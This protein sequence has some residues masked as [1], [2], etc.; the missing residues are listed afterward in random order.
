MGLRGGTVAKENQIITYQ[1]SPFVTIPLPYRNPNTDVWRKSYNGYTLSLYDTFDEKEDLANE[2]SKGL[3]Y[4]RYGRLALSLLVTKALQT[5]R[6]DI[7]MGGI[8]DT[9][10]HLSLPLSG[11]KRGSAGALTDQL[12]KISETSM[13][14]NYSGPVADGVQGIITQKMHLVSKIELYWG[15]K[16]NQ[17]SLFENQITLSADFFNYIEKFSV[18]VDLKTYISIQSALG[19][20]IYAWLCKRFSSLR[21]PLIIPWEAIYWQF[22]PISATG[23]P[24]FRERFLKEVATV[25]KYYPDA[26]ISHEHNGIV[27]RPSKTHIEK[28][29]EGR[30]PLVES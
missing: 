27:L 4:S 28:R 13:R 11:G 16:E 14:F 20:D 29:N 18:P 19:Q 5:G 30:I 1:P 6:P 2:R 7:M 12:Y 23:K 21:K 10:K 17:L 24:R 25:K 3:P 22:G 9:L 15:T 26:H 8:T